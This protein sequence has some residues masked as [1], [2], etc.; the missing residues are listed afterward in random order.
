MRIS[1]W[2][3]FTTIKRITIILIALTVALLLSLTRTVEAEAPTIKT[4]EQEETIEQYIIRRFQEENLPTHFILDLVQAESE[5]NPNAYNPEWHRGCQGSYGLFQIACLHN[6]EN[7][8]ALYDEKF[9]VEM[10]IK[11]AK[12]DGFSPWGVCRSKVNCTI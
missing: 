9:N 3:K 2:T 5:F 7:P 4:V 10:A 6:I 8:Q 1:D 11:I 12:R